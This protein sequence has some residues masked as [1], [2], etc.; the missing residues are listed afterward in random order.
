MK[1]LQISADVV[2]PLDNHSLDL[3]VQLEKKSIWRTCLEVHLF[4]VDPLQ[5]S[6]LVM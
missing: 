3:A 2:R 6:R 1:C 4:L 5:L